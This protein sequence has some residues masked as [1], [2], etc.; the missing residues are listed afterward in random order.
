MILVG[1]GGYS[2]WGALTGG[3][4]APP[5]A[6]PTGTGYADS[7][8]RAA[9]HA[10]VAILL[11]L[12]LRILKDAYRFQ[13]DVNKEIEGLRAERANLERLATGATGARADILRSSIQATQTLETGMTQ[14]RDAIFNLRLGAVEPAQSVIETGVAQ[15]EASIE[16]WRSLGA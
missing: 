16:R 11:G 13:Y 12:N 14:W 3:D 2:A 1:F 6:L 7:A 5:A 8:N 10:N 4:D 15:L 9:F